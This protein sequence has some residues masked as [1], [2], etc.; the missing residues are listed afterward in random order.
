MGHYPEPDNFF[1]YNSP[2]AQRSDPNQKNL[3]PKNP[4]MSASSHK[5]PPPPTHQT[6]P[7]AQYED[8]VQQVVDKCNN[9]EDSECNLPARQ[10]YIRFHRIKAAAKVQKFFLK[11][12]QSRQIGTLLKTHMCALAADM[13]AVSQALHDWLKFMRS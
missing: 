11:V 1:Q 3:H 5:R 7:Y 13:P 4:S 10:L 8:L 9:L 2:H 6:D 12:H